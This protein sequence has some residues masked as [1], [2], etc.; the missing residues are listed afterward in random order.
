MLLWIVDCVI[1]RTQKLSL[2]SRT[3]R[4]QTQNL[5]IALLS[6]PSENLSASTTENALF[7]RVKPQI[8][9][10]IG[11]SHPF[12]S[13][14]AGSD[15]SVEN[16]CSDG[17]AANNGS[18]GSTANNSQVTP[19]KPGWGRP[20][21]PRFKINFDGVHKNCGRVT[22]AAGIARD[23]EGT[24]GVSQLAWPRR[25]VYLPKLN[26]F[27]FETAL[28]FCLDEGIDI[29]NVDFETDSHE[30]CNTFKEKEENEEQKEALTGKQRRDKREAKKQC[31]RKKSQLSKTFL[32]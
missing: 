8:L 32:S 4:S 26:F 18:G 5:S 29:E 23:W 24:K 22:G 3:A 13:G 27:A 16:N 17:S 14:S 20:S 28:R 7:F 10:R 30:V 25:L 9:C 15:G 2:L 19:T 6:R 12:A 31:N 11:F 21:K 1:A